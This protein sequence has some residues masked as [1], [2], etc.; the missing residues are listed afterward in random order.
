MIW[1]EH[2]TGAWVAFAVLTVTFVVLFTRAWLG[3][4][5]RVPGM[6]FPAKRRLSGVKKGLRARLVHLPLA[7][8]GV[9]VAV[10]IFALTRPQMQ[11]TEDIEVEGIDIVVAFDMS[12]SMAAVDISDEDLVQLQNAGKEPKSRFK[13]ATEVLKDFIGSRQHDRVSMVTFGEG[14]FLQFPL[15]LDYGVMLT[16]LNEMALNDIDGSGTVIGNALGMSLNRLADS[17]AKTQVIILLTDGEDKGSNLAPLEMA[18]VAAKGHDANEDGDFD[19]KGDR[20]KVRIFTILV[21]TDGQSRHPTELQDPYTGQRIY[22]KTSYPVN[23]T[24]LKEIAVETGGRFFRAGDK[25]ELANDFREILDD[26]E[27][28]RLV[29]ASGSDPVE[30]FPLFIFLGLGLLTLEVLLAQ[31]VLRRFP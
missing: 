7:V 11:Q 27:K 8:R 31:T 10:L 25:K 16:I 12:G 17:K 9:A 14:A 26:F 28:S 4:M 2:S 13:I 30:L 18:R 23:P 5:S 20:R 19:D 24:L 29:D 3:R 15:T 22:K 6:R 1:P 21:G